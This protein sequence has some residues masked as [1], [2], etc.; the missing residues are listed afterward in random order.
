MKQIRKLPLACESSY[1]Y[2]IYFSRRAT[3]C[4]VDRKEKNNFPL[5]YIL[6]T[7]EEKVCFI[8]KNSLFNL[9]KTQDFFTIFLL[10][11]EKDMLQ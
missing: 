6:K 9:T 4:Q 1:C 3:L 2:L 10:I 5:F 7:E 11:F 8:P